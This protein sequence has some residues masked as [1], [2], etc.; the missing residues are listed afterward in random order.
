MAKEKK[1]VAE[2][3]LDQGVIIQKQW[4]AARG[5]EKKT[6]QTMRKVLI[7]LGMIT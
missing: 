4:E 3:L 5:E 6:G 1:S 7:K 2:R